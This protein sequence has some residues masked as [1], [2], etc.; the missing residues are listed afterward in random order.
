MKRTILVSLT[1]S[2][3]IIIIAC[4]SDD[5]SPTISNKQ[6]Y[7]SYYQDNILPSITKFKQELELLKKITSDFQT[8]TTD[9]NY[10]KIVL[11]W[12]EAAKAYSKA[13][14]YN[15]GM[16]KQRFYDVN[17]Y[18]YPINT[19]KIESNIIEA[20]NFDAN[21]FS[22]KSTV[23]KG[24]STVEYLLYGNDFNMLQA[25]EKLLNNSN[26]FN[27]L[28]GTINELLRQSDGIINTWKDEY[29]QIYINAD[30]SICTENAK[31]LTINQII[32]VLDIAK[33]TRIG[34]PAGFEK[35]DNVDAEILEAYR[36]RN[37]MLLI[38]AMLEEVNH[39]YF[40]S[41]TNISTLVDNINT[42]KEIST[43]I[44]NKLNILEEQIASFNNN[45]FD[46]VNSN[47]QS[48][49]PMYISLKELTT[50]FSVDVTSILSVT[51]LP[52][53]NDGD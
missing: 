35:S 4:G 28:I 21:Y 22:T 13:E 12:L 3:F 1:L 7:T 5:D 15:F 19:N 6:F 14:V 49:R 52:T 20:T 39:V 42:S 53:D 38:K 32:N 40:N 41:N 43:Q 2:L 17:I 47:P 26:R 45:L 9:E 11:Q 36:S 8:S 18:N 16:I 48:I 51:T 30:Q 37:S 29:F 25:K 24:L 33:V 31:C 34:K 50:L 44:K 23:T 10:Q 27:Y 46:A